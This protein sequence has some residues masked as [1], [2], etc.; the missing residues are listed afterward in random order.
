VEVLFL[1][2]LSVYEKRKKIEDPRLPAVS[3][4]CTSNVYMKMIME[5]WWND[6]DRRNRSTRRVT[7]LPVALRSPHI[8][9]VLAWD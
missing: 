8:S 1:S 9:Y 3:L 7:S 5:D 4:F 6:T 2:V